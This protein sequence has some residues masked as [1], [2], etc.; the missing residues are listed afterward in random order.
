MTTTF[1]ESLD[2]AVN[3]AQD[4]AR[5]SYANKPQVADLAAQAAAAQAAAESASSNA[6]AAASDAAAAQASAASAAALVGAPSG[7]AIDAYIGSGASV[8]VRKDT[9]F[10]LASEHGVAGDNTTDDAAALN[11]LLSSAA[12]FG[13]GVKLAAL[14][15]VKVVASTI[16][17]PSGTRLDLNGST[18]RNARTG[19]SDRLLTLSSVSNVT[20]ENGTIDGDKAS[21][22]GVTEQRHNIH[23]INSSGITLRNLTTKNAKG[24]GLYIGDDV[25]GA[26]TDIIGINVSGLYNHR[27]GLSITAGKRLHFYG[28]QWSYNAGTS[29]MAGVDIEPNTDAA[30]WED[31]TFHGVSFNNNGY[32][33]VNVQAKSAAPTSRQAGVAFTDC[34]A[35]NNGAS[36]TFPMVDFGNGVHIRYAQKVRWVGGSI[37][38]NVRFG[39]WLRDTLTD[40]VIDSAI[41]ANG[42]EGIGQPSGSVTDLTIRGVIWGNGLSNTDGT[43]ATAGSVDGVNLAGSG[44]RLRFNATSGGAQQRYGLRTVSTWSHVT[45]AAGARFPSN[46][47]GALSMSDDYSTRSV[48]SS[49]GGPWR[50]GRAAT[51]DTALATRI[52]GDSVDRYSFRQDGRMQWSSGA[53]AIDVTLERTAA[54]TVGVGAGHAI[55]T[56]RAV[57]AS[58]PSASTVGS[59]A[60][61]YDTTL[62]KPIWSDG[63][64]WK[65][66]TGTAV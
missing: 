26:C 19:S 56:G 27:N 4:A 64:T 6:S 49:D 14:T 33:G 44:T 52:T 35:A 1:P 11:S 60:M 51:G 37:R 9:A 62:S 23:V 40:I 42:R 59:G 55:R 10:M 2:A 25:T 30:N 20:I 15:T 46:T 24:D 22:A 31:I 53:A 21:Y 29:P 16:T 57:T 18:I 36:I 7:S 48:A 39:V 34:V 65:D 50:I 43:A 13:L 5:A 28:G 45:L 61:F 66:A 12:T 3:A 17:V 63:T 8:A 47:T 32:D 58:R 41:E 54:G 38:S